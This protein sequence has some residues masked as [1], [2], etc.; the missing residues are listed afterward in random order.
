MADHEQTD[1]GCSHS[2]ESNQ[3]SRRDIIKSVIAAGAGVLDELFVPR[4]ESVGAG[5]GAGR[6]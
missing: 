2:N 6:G 4:L 5:L 1:P 3:I